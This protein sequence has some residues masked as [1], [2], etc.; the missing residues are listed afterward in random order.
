M[1]KPKICLISLSAY[2]ILSSKNIEIVGGSEVQQALLAREL[3][4]KGFDISFIVFDYGQK[5]PEIIDNI[6]IFPK[7][8]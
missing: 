8:P 2:P 7:S 6:K 3:K 5:S 1:S 4:K